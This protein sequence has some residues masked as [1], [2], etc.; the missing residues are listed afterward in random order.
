[1]YSWIPDDANGVYPKVISTILAM[2]SK[3]EIERPGAVDPHTLELH[4]ASLT[5]TRPERRLVTSYGRPINVAFALAEAMWILAGRRDVEMLAGYNST[6]AQFSDDGVKFNAAY[7]Y[8]LRSDFGHDQIE[9]VIRTLKDDPSS[10]QATLVISNPVD[11]KG[12]DRV[13]SVNG[14]VHDW[15]YS[16]HQT[17]D[18]ACNVL[19]HPMIRDGALDWMQVIRSNDAVWGTP[20]NWMQFTHLMEWIAV[21]VGAA[22][23]KYNHIVDSLHIYSH[24]FADAKQ[25]TPFDLYDYAEVPPQMHV[26]MSVINTV[27]REELIIRTSN[28]EWAPPMQV[29][30][31]IGTYWYH[32]LKL[33]YA[34]RLY[35]AGEDTKCAALLANTLPIYGWAQARFY[36]ANRWHKPGYKDCIDSIGMPDD[37]CKWA[38]TRNED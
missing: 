6:I 16:K 10:R 17:K 20:Y 25:I 9:D 32:C 23:G 38:T 21:S 22:M 2:G 4:P 1:M 29:V 3:V 24:H 31:T 11:D 37:V 35:V 15:N 18:R 36:Y 26:G 19:A 5:M 8:R 13:P 27:L 28:Q 7:G 34:H 30:D 14:G 12:W 33:L